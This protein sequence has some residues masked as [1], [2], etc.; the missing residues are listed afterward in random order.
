MK[1]FLLVLSVISLL[2]GCKRTHSTEYYE[3]HLSEA[4]TKDKVCFKMAPEVRE[5][6]KDCEYAYHAIVR[7]NLKTIK[8]LK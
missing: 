4:Q 7:A 5:A 6:D 8:P 2:G 1:K 3:Q